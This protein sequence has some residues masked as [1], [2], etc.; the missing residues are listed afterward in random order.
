MNGA[1]IVNN[2]QLAK[3]FV[4]FYALFNE[5]EQVGVS[6]QSAL[7][8]KSVAQYDCLVSA[9]LWHYSN[10]ILVLRHYLCGK[11]IKQIKWSLL[12]VVI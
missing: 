11:I 7:A 6:E 4:H 8:D 3:L 9:F 12:T 10:L 1:F 5:I 2:P